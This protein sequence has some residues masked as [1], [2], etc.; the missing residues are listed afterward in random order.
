MKFT[1][2]KRQW[3]IGTKGEGL[4]LVENFHGSEDGG[5]GDEVEPDGED[6]ESGLCSD[7]D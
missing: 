5:D 2:W 3:R 4:V 6:V 7:G 1:R